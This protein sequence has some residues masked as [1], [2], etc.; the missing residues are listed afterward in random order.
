MALWAC[1]AI[2]QGMT[3]AELLRYKIRQSQ[4]LP[5]NSKGTPAGTYTSH[6]QV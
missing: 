4:G 3:L 5:P 6:T 2:K 1:L